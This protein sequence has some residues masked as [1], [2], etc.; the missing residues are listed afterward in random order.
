MKLSSSQMNFCIKFEGKPE[1]QA[2]KV[3]DQPEPSYDDEGSLKDTKIIF[4]KV[5]NFHI[6][7]DKTYK[8]II[9]SKERR[10][11]ID[12]DHIPQKMFLVDRNG[13]KFEII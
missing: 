13:D 8:M 2:I 11:I 10:I 9:S 3:L 1:I 4:A 6:P 12:K 7:D 5:N